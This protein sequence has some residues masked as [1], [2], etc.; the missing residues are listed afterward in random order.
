MIKYTVLLDVV[1]IL[2]DVETS[3]IQALDRGF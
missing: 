3:Y 2:D 1:G